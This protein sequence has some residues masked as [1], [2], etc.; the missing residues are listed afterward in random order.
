MRLELRTQMRLLLTTLRAG[1]DAWLGLVYP[2]V[3]QVCGHQRATPPAGYVCDACRCGHRGVRFLIP[4]LCERCGRPFPGD[5]TTPFEC[6]NCRDV[7]LYFQWARSAVA[8][9]GVV[10]DVIHRYKY[11]GALWFEPF[12]INLLVHA[13]LPTLQSGGSWNCLVPVPLHPARQRE[14]EF[15][16]AERLA[17]GLSRAAG[18]PVETRCLERTRP[19]RTQTQLSREERAENMRGAF[20]VRRGACCRG[21]RVVL[22]DDVFTTGATTNACARA[23]T[24]AGAAAVCVWTLARG[25]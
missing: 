12:L 10:L 23:L 2:N 16:Q 22:V 6:S 5:L 17:Q 25:L 20:A 18:L 11:Q 15:N 19:T 4:P 3:C 21:A 1:G 14:R 24:A 7:K 8:A 13:A 9:E